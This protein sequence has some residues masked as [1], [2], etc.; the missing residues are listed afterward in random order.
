LHGWFK[1][2][3]WEYCG[4]LVVVVVVVVVVAVVAVVAVVVVSDYGLRPNPTYA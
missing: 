3:G 1:Q 4:T 2:N